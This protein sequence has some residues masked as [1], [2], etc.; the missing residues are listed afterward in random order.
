M[1]NDVITP[2]MVESRLRELSKE[3]DKAHQDL[4]ASETAYNEVK[5]NY[6][7]AMAKSRMKYAT[8]SSPTGKNYT[9]QEREDLALIDNETLFQDLGIVDAQ[10]KAARANTQRLRIQVEIARS[11]G[12]SV[13]TSMDLT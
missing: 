10:V 2:A 4:L 6:E 11:V 3:V 9:V 8:T 1:A 5:G 13:R 12:T 7:I